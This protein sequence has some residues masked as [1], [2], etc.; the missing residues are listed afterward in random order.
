MQSIRAAILYE[1]CRCGFKL[2]SSN[3]AADMIDHRVKRQ[4]SSIDANGTCRANQR[5]RFPLTVS[6]VALGDGVGLAVFRAAGSP[7]GFI[8]K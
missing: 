2:S 6:L 4:R 5:C 8:G 7:S 1:L 3:Q